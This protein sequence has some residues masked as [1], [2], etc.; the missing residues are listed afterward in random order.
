MALNSANNMGRKFSYVYAFLSPAVKLGLKL[1]HRRWETH[2]TENVPEG[3]VLLIANHQNGM[4]DP[5]VCCL[6]MTR[7]CHFLTRADIFA[8]P[9][10]NTLLRRLNMIPVY[11]PRDR[12]ANA[13]D[14]NAQSFATARERLAQGAIVSL[15]PEGNH[16]NQHSLRPFKTGVARMAFESLEAWE[17]VP[18][19]PK[20]IAILPVGLEYENYPKFRNSLLVNIGTPIYA[21]DLLPLFKTDQK[22]AI[23]Q[24]I[25]RARTA[26]LAQ[27]I[28]L[29]SDER[30]DIRLALLDIATWAQDQKGS[31]R[32]RTQFEQRKICADQ[33]ERF[34][35]AKR[36]ACDQALL[37]YTSACTTLGMSLHNV[38]RKKRKTG[39][40]LRSLLVALIG[41]P[42]ALFG[43][44]VHFPI[45]W[46]THVVVNKKIKDTHFKSSFGLAVPG[47]ALPIWWTVLYIAV[48]LIW[49]PWFAPAFLVAAIPSAMLTLFFR[50]RMLATRNALRLNALQRRNPAA[51]TEANDR[52]Q[53]LLRTLQ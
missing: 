1:W 3:P 27:M 45:A 10:I 33:L 53:E 12:K 11:R 23:D 30:Y 38:P 7:Q 28:H 46:L 37:D 42:I 2:G 32:L 44:V 26:L 20:E 17:S 31:G 16:K 13:K 34:T 47:L 50:D 6:E 8:K 35:E 19:S 29:P 52:L 40:L 48:A 39:Y 43:A 5:V 18:D 41:L 51:Y 21:A 22:A 9:R 14:L 49:T 15:F 4:E 25:Q 36:S 24:L